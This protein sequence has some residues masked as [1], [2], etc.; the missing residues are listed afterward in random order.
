MSFK[1]I[2]VH[3]DRSQNC[4]ARLALA[5]RVALTLGTVAKDVLAHM[6]IPVLMSH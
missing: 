2:L 5:T 1:D 3:I 6:T 4:P